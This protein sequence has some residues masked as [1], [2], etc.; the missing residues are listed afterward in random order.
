[1][2]GWLVATTLL[3]VFALVLNKFLKKAHN[4]S[5]YQ[6]YSKSVKASL[7]ESGVFTEHGIVYDSE[8]KAIVAQHKKSD[9]FYEIAR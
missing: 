5:H 2:I 7:I 9:F 3:V 4:L 6:T 1:M 8:N